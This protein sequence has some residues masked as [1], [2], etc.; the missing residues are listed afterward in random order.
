VALNHYNRAQDLMP[1]KW[2]KELLP[3]RIMGR[4]YVSLLE[5]IKAKNFPV[6][7][8]KVKLSLFEKTWATLKE[9][10]KK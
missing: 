9:V 3:A 2:Q 6:F 7:Q 5:K 4:I 8:K 10:R 1:R